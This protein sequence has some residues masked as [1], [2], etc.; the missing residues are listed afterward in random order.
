M[1]IETVSSYEVGK[2]IV[3]SCSRCE[4]TLLFLFTQ[5]GEDSAH[6]VSA[7]CAAVVVFF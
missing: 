5:P 6:F 7:V 1:R 2:L 3:L 4:F